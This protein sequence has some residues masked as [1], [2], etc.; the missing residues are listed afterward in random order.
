MELDVEVPE[1]DVEGPDLE[2]RHEP[3]AQAK[4]ATG[5]TYTVVVGVWSSGCATVA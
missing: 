4:H 3:E 1:L 2:L 5:I